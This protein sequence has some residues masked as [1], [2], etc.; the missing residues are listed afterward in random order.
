MLR[1]RSQLIEPDLRE[2]WGDPQGDRLFFLDE[3]R[4]CP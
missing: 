4:H 2:P 3:N 1:L